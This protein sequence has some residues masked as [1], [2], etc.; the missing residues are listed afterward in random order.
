MTLLE[1]DSRQQRGGVWERKTADRSLKAG[2]VSPPLTPRIAGVGPPTPTA[3]RVR[4]CPRSSRVKLAVQL[5]TATTP[6]ATS[7]PP[8]AHHSHRRAGGPLPPV[9]PI[10]CSRRAHVRPSRHTHAHSR[11][12]LPL[13][14]PP[15]HHAPASDRMNTP[16]ASP[17][18]A[19]RQGAMCYGRAPRAWRQP[20][21][22]PLVVS[23]ARRRVWHWRP[24]P[25]PLTRREHTPHC[26]CNAAQGCA[27]HHATVV[28]RAVCCGGAGQTPPPR[29][30]ALCR[31]HHPVRAAVGVGP[32]TKRGGTTN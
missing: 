16:A 11:P 10:G 26:A 15:P 17:L 21:N 9:L 18:R 2:W 20:T 4:P 13:P 1:V 24:P 5:A 6:R 31:R 32:L 28:H 27:R 7:A 12:P 23:T 22:P 29:S 3:T 19:P 8:P 30:A 25:P 14:P